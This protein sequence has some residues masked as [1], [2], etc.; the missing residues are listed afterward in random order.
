MGEFHPATG[1]R[2]ARC[3]KWQRALSAQTMNTAKLIYWETA[4]L[5]RRPA[6]RVLTR[7]P[8]ILPPFGCSPGHVDAKTEITLSAAVLDQLEADDIEILGHVPPELAFE[9]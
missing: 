1:R 6:F 8:M 9:I 2:G 3:Q 4:A 7:R 5:D